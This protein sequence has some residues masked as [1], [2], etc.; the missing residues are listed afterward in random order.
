MMLKRISYNVL[1]ISSK[2][3]KICLPQPQRPQGRYFLEENPSNLH[4]MASLNPELFETVNAASLKKPGYI[5]LKA[6][7]VCK[8]TEL[9][10]KPKST[11]KGNDRLHI[12][13]RHLF[14]GKKYEDTINLTAG[15]DCYVQVPFWEKKDYVVLDV[16]EREKTVSILRDE[17]SGDTGEVSFK[18]LFD[19]ADGDGEAHVGQAII[20]K[21]KGGEG[22]EFKV[23]VLSI[24]GR[25]VILDV[26]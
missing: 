6:Q 5:L 22:A 15:N 24:V 10:Q 7:H 26:N 19:D 12:V 21:W 3:Q 25:E 8:I 23:T 2:N 20:E 14:T 4:I 16:D 18:Q 1:S 11:V 17:S 13:G 9:N